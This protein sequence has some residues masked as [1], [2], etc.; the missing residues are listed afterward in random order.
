MMRNQ[1]CSRRRIAGTLTRA[2]GVLVMAA[3]FLARCSSDAPT[4]MSGSSGR[5]LTVAA[6]Q[7]VDIRL[8]NIGSGEYLAPPAISSTAI[9]FE[10]VSLVTPY[11]P[12]GKTQLF[13]FQALR[14]GRALVTFRHSEQSP[15]VIDTVDVR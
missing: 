7:K 6:G 4:D 3:L 9:R 5:T 8:Q 12:A 15:T 1:Q 13:R 11:V 2:G 14:R 10:D